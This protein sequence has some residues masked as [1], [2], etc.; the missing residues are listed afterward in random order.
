MICQA[1]GHHQSEGTEC[2][3]CHT[4]FTSGNEEQIHQLS[5]PSAIEMFEKETSS[6]PVLPEE[7]HEA[8]AKKTLDE[9][10]KNIQEREKQIQLQLAKMEEEKKRLLELKL[11]HEKQM[12]EIKEKEER[13]KAQMKETEIVSA[14]DKF[15][16]ILVTSLSAIENKPVLEYKGLVGAQVLIKA[17]TLD[18]AISSLKDASGLRNTP[19]YDNL[20]KGF[21]IGLTDLKIEASK[22]QANAVVGVVIQQQFIKDQALILSFTGTAVLV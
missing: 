13:K 14:V 22:L 12:Q 11:N 7:S 20:R 2:L 17:D 8:L 16:N 18:S 4:V 6:P 19:Y 9:Q 15:K 5:T 21:Q 10:A 3:K 1:C